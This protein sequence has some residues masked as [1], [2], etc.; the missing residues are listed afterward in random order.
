MHAGDTSAKTNVESYPP[1]L[2]K[3]SIVMIV[4]VFV[5]VFMCLGN[6]TSDLF[7]IFF[8]RVTYGDGS[9]LFWPRCDTICTSGCINDV[10]FAHSGSY[11]GT[12]IPLHRCAQTNAPAASYWLR[13]VL[14]HGGRHDNSLYALKW[15]GKRLSSHTAATAG[16][17]C[18][19]VCRS[20]A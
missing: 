19:D 7:R 8:M 17:V 1:Q 9:D 13:C 11:G 10:M 2:R 14:D 4:S 20:R 12:S 18:A 15:V 6:Y 5:C 16:G 3:R